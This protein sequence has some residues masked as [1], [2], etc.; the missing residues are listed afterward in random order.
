[1]PPKKSYPPPNPPAKAKIPAE[2]HHAAGHLDRGNDRAHA[3][4]HAHGR[5]HAR[6]HAHAHAHARAR[7]H[8]RDEGAHV[9]QFQGAN[10]QSIPP[11]IHLYS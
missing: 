2:Y 9:S 10:L 3:N 5:A 7:A 6:A 1:M 11:E 4:V 8:A